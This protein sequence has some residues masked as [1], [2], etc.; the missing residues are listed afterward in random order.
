MIQLLAYYDEQV[1]MDIL[2]GKVPFAHR[3]SGCY[4]M[5]DTTN[6]KPEFKWPNK[7]YITNSNAKKPAYDDRSIAQWVSGQ[8]YNITQGRIQHW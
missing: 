2:Q 7:G 5:A 3:K 6:V 1:D 4:N 8:L